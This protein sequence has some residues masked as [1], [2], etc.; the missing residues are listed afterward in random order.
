[1]AG[2]RATLTLSSALA[3]LVLALPLSAGA[4]RS[5]TRNIAVVKAAFNKKLKKRIL[6]TDQGMTL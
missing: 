3:L 6:V 5:A 4:E 1:M 2:R